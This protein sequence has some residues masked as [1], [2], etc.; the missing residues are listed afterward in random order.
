M[1][2]QEYPCYPEGVYGSH[3]PFFPLRIKRLREPGRDDVTEPQDAYVP[4]LS[5]EVELIARTSYLLGHA[6]ERA[7]Q[8]ERSVRHERKVA[9]KLG[10][11]LEETKRERDRYESL[12]EGY[13]NEI[14]TLLDS[15][16]KKDNRIKRLT[17]KKEGKK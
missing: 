16:K 17:P 8:A 13:S 11:K 14:D 7:V 3:D 9:E 10:S 6:E 4:N 12:A 5:G 2:D 15:V 1:F